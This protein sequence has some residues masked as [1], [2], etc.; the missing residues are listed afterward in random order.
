MVEGTGLRFHHSSDVVTCALYHAQIL[1][2]GGH[3][4]QIVCRF[5]VSFA[6]KCQSRVLSDSSFCDANST[7]HASHCISSSF[8]VL[9]SPF[10][11]LNLGLICLY[12]SYKKK[13]AS[14][15]IED[16]EIHLTRMRCGT[17][18]AARNLLH[19]GSTAGN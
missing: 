17:A 6:R 10:E 9:T 5:C 12:L 7:F 1:R 19:L 18:K 16:D 3:R 13:T 8:R 14:N 15:P 2:T 11:S 4:V